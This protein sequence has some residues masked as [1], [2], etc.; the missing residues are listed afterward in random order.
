MYNEGEQV[1]RFLVAG[2]CIDASV[3]L[4]GVARGCPGVVLDCLGCTMFRSTV[5]S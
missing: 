3:E 5:S 1:L 2:Q 4:Q